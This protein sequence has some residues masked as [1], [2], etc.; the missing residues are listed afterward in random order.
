[1]GGMSEMVKLNVGSIDDMGN[2]FIGAWHQLE[3]GEDVQEIN[4][5]FFDWKQMLVYWFGRAI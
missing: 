1:M 4:L 3:R 5:T 2:R